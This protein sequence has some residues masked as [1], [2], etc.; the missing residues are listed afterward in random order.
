MLLPKEH[1]RA[2]LVRSK[3]KETFPKL[4]GVTDLLQISF[5]CSKVASWTSFQIYG[6][7]F[8][9]NRKGHQRASYLFPM[10]RV[11][12]RSPAPAK[13]THLGA[14]NFYGQATSYADENISSAHRGLRLVKSGAIEKC[15]DTPHLWAD[16]EHWPEFPTTHRQPALGLSASL[17]TIFSI[18]VG[19]MTCL[20][21]CILQFAADRQ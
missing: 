8:W 7:V 11:N 6:S 4:L 2:V 19:N 9:R 17:Y 10:G 3:H 13:N 20:C 21:A 15:S 1:G 5:M 14:Y 16:A 12:K 18:S